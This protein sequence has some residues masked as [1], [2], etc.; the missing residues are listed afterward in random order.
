MNRKL[1]FVVSGL[2]LL[3]SVSDLRAQGVSYAYDASG[4]RVSREVVLSQAKSLEEGD[5][6]SVAEVFQTLQVHVRADGSSGRVEITI[7]GVGGEDISSASAIAFAAGGTRI[8]SVAFASDG[9]AYI[10]LSTRPAGVYLI[11]VRCG[12]YDQTWRIVKK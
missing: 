10:D 4:N 7:T 9:M 11:R 5:M 3:F 12:R 1:L 6:S 2:L 8:A